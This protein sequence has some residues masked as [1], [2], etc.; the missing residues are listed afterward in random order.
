MSRKPFTLRSM[1][2][3]TA[4][5]TSGTTA[6]SICQEIVTHVQPSLPGFSQLITAIV[7]LWVIDKLNNLVDDTSAGS[8]GP[9]S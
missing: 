6:G 3:T 2:I 1:V 8:R 9:T 5:L 4:G 7:A